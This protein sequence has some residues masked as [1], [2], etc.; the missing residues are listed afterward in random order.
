M[1]AVLG[2]NDL[3]RALLGEHLTPGMAFDCSLYDQAPNPQTCAQAARAAQ[4]K[5][6]TFVF[7]STS[8]V[9]A[10]QTSRLRQENET[11]NPQSDWAQ[12]ALDCE[13][14]ATQA[15]CG[16]LVFRLGWL[17]SKDSLGWIS[18]LRGQLETCE[19]LELNDQQLG[20]PTPVWW[21]AQQ[22]A[23]L[24]A[25]WSGLE[26]P[27]KA[28]KVGIYHLS[29]SGQVSPL[30]VAQELLH[31]LNLKGSLHCR[32]KPLKE[33]ARQEQLSNIKAAMN[34]GL[35]QLDWKAAFFVEW[36]PAICSPKK[37]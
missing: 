35:N 30:G 29:C 34:L 7:F 5:G 4:E 21:V 16:T 33:P 8:E 11:P 37:P 20:Q 25:Y 6:Q 14:A 28:K 32:L 19:E 12:L 23:R 26:E 10:A 17:F 3:S 18:E 24:S 1:S 13:K 22:A 2:A 31:A 15:H 36:A 9:Y 27:Q